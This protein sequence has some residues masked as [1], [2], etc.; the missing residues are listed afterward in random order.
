MELKQLEYVIAI[1]DCGS[2]SKAAD[3]LFITQSGL[4]QQLIRLESE[5]GIKLFDRDKHYLKMTEAGKIYVKKAREIMLIKKDTYNILSDLKNNKVGEINLGLTLEHGIDLFTYVFPKFNK[6]FPGINFHLLERYVSQQHSLLTAGKLDF[7]LVMLGE[8]DKIN[9]EYIPLFSEDMILGVPR[10]H[11]YAC[12]STAPDKHMPVID[13]KLFENETFALMFPNS[14]MRNIID[15]A[16]CE[17]SYQPKILIET[18][19]NHA[20]VKLAATGLC[21]TIL[22]HSRAICSPYKNDVAWFRLSSPA[23]WTTYITYR[24]NTNLN[25]ASRYFIELSKEYGAELTQSLKDT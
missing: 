11:P 4:N 10:S 1:A 15:S 2:I 9:L 7:G 8:Q 5:L 17:A 13:L 18:G 14:T 16:F 3:S 12:A 23:S 20:L 25:K 19:M 24:K 21:C 6:C 22:P